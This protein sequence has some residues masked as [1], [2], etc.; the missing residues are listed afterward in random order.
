MAVQP[1]KRA[2]AAQVAEWGG[3]LTERY[4]VG[5]WTLQAEARQTR[6]TQ[7]QLRCDRSGFSNGTT[8]T[9]SP[10]DGWVIYDGDAR[11]SSHRSPADCLRWWSERHMK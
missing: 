10:H 4:R 11:F 5:P 8:V 2:W 7:Y 1:D 3:T 6:P 9:R